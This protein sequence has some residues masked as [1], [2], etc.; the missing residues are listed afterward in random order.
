M[1]YQAGDLVP[2]SIAPKKNH[3][4]Q[5]FSEGVKE[6]YLWGLVPE[7]HDIKLD[8]LIDELGMVSAANIRIEEYQTWRSKVISL[9]SFGMLVPIN[10]RISAFGQ[11]EE[12]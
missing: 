4:H 3:K 12:N 1:H 10:Y 8:E 11:R 7:K 5:V 6:F 2:V 9:I